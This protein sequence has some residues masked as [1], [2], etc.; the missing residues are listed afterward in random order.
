M[1]NATAAFV[2]WSPPPPQHH[3]GILLGYKVQAIIILINKDKVINLPKGLIT[4]ICGDFKGEGTCISQPLYPHYP[5][6]N[7]LGKPVN[8]IAGF[9][10]QM[11]AS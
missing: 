1:L 6:E 3:N 7:I 11:Q 8:C 2:R 9:C 5:L 4:E 10:M